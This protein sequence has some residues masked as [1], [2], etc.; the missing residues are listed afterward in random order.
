[1]VATVSARALIVRAAIEADVAQWG[2]SPQR[3][4][5]TARRPSI[6]STTTAAGSVGARL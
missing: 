6:R 3:K 5:T 2:I 1:V 4:A